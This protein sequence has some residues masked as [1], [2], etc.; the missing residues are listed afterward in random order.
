MEQIYSWSRLT[1]LDQVKMVILGQV[2]GPTRSSQGDS[3]VLY[4]ILTITSVKH[5]VS[6]IGDDA[7][8]LTVILVTYDDGHSGLS[9]S[10]LPPT[11]LPGSLRNIYKQLSQDIPGFKPPSS[12][13]VGCCLYYDKVTSASVI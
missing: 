2:G 13:C 3:L 11:K 9:F 4:R 8:V 12:G 7:T 1:P 5:M 10:V 6:F